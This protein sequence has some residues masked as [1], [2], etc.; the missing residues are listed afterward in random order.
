MRTSATR[1]VTFTVR[2]PIGREDLPGLSDRACALLGGNPG[3][4]VLCHVEQVEPDAVTIEA[5][6]RLQ[7][8]AHSNRCQVRVRN[9]SPALLDLVAFMGLADVL[10]D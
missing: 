10:P 8:V 1:T 4:T 7:L 3:T 2:G 5:L 6:A 9:A